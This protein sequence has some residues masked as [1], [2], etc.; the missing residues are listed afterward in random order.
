MSLRIIIKPTQIS[1]WITARNGTPVR[2]QGTD[3]DVRVLF[4]DTAAGYEPISID[5]L[6]EAMKFNNLAM[7]VDQEPGKTQHKFI[8][9]S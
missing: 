5:E 2:R 3:A 7:L 4:G 8:Q 1:E 9:H 6:L